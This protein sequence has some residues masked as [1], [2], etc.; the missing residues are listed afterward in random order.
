MHARSFWF[1][2]AAALAIVVFFAMLARAGGP[3]YVAGSSY[4]NSLTMGQPIIWSLGQVSYY[5]DQ[6]DLSPILP[7]AAA[8]S[9]VASAFSQWTSVSIAALT[10]TNAGQLAEDVN[11]SNIGVDSNG[12][13]NA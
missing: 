2:L 10:A 11:G 12:T 1:R 3:E 7:N 9:L 5:T 4:F 8:N 13:I 6:G